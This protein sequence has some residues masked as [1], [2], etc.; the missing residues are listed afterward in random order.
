MWEILLA[1]VVS[2][3]A[4]VRQPRQVPTAPF[5][6]ELSYKLENLILPISLLQPMV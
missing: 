5:D 1:T 6:Y 2:L 4:G 3:S